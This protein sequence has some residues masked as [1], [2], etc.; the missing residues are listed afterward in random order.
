MP[1]PPLT[2]AVVTK[3]FHFE[4]KQRQR[5]ADTGIEMLKE[6]ADT[7][8]TIPND[9]LLTMAPRGCSVQEAFRMADNVLLQAVKGISDV[10]LLPGLVNVDFQD[11]KNIM[12]NKGQALM[13]TGIAS[14]PDR[15]ATAAQAAISSPLL[16]DISIEGAQGILINISARENEI[17]LDEV[18]QACSLIQKEADPDANIIFGRGLGQHPGRQAAHHGHRHRHRPEAAT[19]HHPRPEGK[20][21]SAHLQPQRHGHQRRRPGTADVPTQERA[22]AQ[23]EGIQRPEIFQIRK[24]HRG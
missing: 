2:V 9:R 19:D 7:I 1:D 12:S 21:A 8:I 17:T 10:I 13:G 24:L 3:P 20:K 11:A 6:F 14:G 23:P 22:A 4:G 18:D 16:E 15:A 5:L